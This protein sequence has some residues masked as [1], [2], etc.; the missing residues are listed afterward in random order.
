V[1]PA[2]GPAA[3]RNVGWRRATGRIIAFTDDDTIPRADWIAQ[4]FSAFHDDVVAATG[5][6]HVPLSRKPPSD[7]ELDA[8]RLSEGE[9]V[10]ANCFV[11]R[12]ALMAVNG[13]DE[14]FTAAW[15]EDSD[16][17]FS[18][19]EA[20]G[21]VVSASD[22]VVVHPVRPA[23]WG[24]SLRQQRKILFDALLYKKHP[25]LY[26]QRIRRAP[27][28]NYY[29]VVFAIALTFLSVIQGWG[30]LAAIAGLVWAGITTEFCVRRLRHTSHA[31][32][33]VLE[34]IASSI[35]I[36]PLAVFWRLVGAVRFRAY[37]F[38]V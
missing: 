12:K 22:A 26:R 19:I 16:L 21:R 33:H 27:P 10:T 28:W 5:V 25:R 13:F 20:H 32:G 36:P 6:V 15:R 29:A 23:H 17:F 18:L 8:S 11:K 24:V 7:Y 37:S 38:F 30:G 3:A 9:F 1:G 34:M 35:L 4:G 31:P 2:H 14:R